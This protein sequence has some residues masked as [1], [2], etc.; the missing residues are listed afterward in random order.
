MPVPFR[1]SLLQHAIIGDAFDGAAAHGRAHVAL[2][3]LAV[4]AEVLGGFLV[5]RVRS[6]G[7]EKKELFPALVLYC[8]R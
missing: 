2:E 8:Q 5:Q 7:F 3:A 6:V 4:V 1:L